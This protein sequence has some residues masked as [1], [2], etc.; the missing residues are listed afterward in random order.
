MENSANGTTEGRRNRKYVFGIIVI[1]IGLVLLGSNWGF[2]SYGWKHIFFSWQMLLIAIGLISLSSRDNWV[3]GVILVT[4]GGFF[5]LPRLFF[6]PPN[7]T[8]LFWPAI[9]IVAGLLIIFRKIPGM[10][11]WRRNP[12][13]SHR[14]S[15]EGYIHE[16]VVFGDTKPRVTSQEFRGGR[17]SCVFGNVELD[18][19]QAR[20]AEGT[21]VLDLNVV[22]GGITVIVPSDWKIELKMSSVLGGFSDKRTLI[23]P[24]LD[25]T[26]LLIIKGGAVFGGGEIKSY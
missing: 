21:H 12:E 16:E 24:N 18:L 9:L 25:P 26:R 5:L 1:L 20:L 4:I 6:L 10:R 15:Q 7:F 3:P 2:I 22:F 13:A 8:H 23:R 19:M 14:I 11:E 17:V